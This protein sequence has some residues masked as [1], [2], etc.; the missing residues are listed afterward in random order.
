MSDQDF[1][2]SVLPRLRAEAAY[3][4][5]QLTLAGLWS[6]PRM[7]RGYATLALHQAR[8]RGRLLAAAHAQWAGVDDELLFACSGAVAGVACVAELELRQER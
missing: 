6:L 8:M 1:I 5:S 2:D 7:H 3:V 4:T